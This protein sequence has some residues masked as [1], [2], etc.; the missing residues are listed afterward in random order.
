MS[1]QIITITSQL[2][3]NQ[4]APVKLRYAKKKR[5]VHVF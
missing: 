3:N 4:L 5:S 2:M 1:T